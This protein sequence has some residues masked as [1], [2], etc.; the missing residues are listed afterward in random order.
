MDYISPPVDLSFKCCACCHIVNLM[1]YSEDQNICSFRRHFP[2]ALFAQPHYPTTVRLNLSDNHL[3]YI[4]NFELYSKQYQCK[5]CFKIWQSSS[6]CKRHSSS[7]ESKDKLVFPGGFVS[8]HQ[9][10]FDQLKEFGFET[11]NT[12]YP[13]FIVY[14]FE[15]IQPPVQSAG[16]SKLQHIREHIPVSVSVCSNVPGFTEPKCFVNLD[17]D[18]LVQ[19]M[20]S[21]IEHI[22]YS[23][24]ELAEERWGYELALLGAEVEGLKEKPAALTTDNQT[25]ND[26]M[27]SL[28][29]KLEGYM[30]RIPVLGFCSSRYDINLVKEK[31]LFHLNLHLTED[32]TPNF[33]IKKCNSYVCKSSQHFRFLD[34]AQYLAPHSR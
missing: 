24:Y 31:L 26:E 20:L 18:Q 2:I 13:W 21:Y 14:D 29:C 4:H 27:F 8:I 34:M 16:D 23:A 7:C 28:R 11:K 9:N 25:Q 5:F 32:N 15:A 22:S 1:Q 19:D 17:P 6:V 3:S 10:I 30:K 33:V 12:H